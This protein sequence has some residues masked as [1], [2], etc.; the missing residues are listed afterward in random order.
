MDASK[1]KAKFT[2][3]LWAVF[4]NS[5]GNLRT[6]DF[7]ED[8]GR[9][10]DLAWR[11]MTVKLGKDGD[12]N[13]LQAPNGNLCISFTQVS[14]ASLEKFFKAKNNCPDGYVPRLTDKNPALAF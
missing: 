5:R 3:Q 14:K 11:M 13:F 12:I 7:S 6:A 10:S 2:E 9:H 8:A 4:D 1:A